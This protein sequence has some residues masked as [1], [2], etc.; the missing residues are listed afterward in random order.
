MM[1]GVLLLGNNFHFKAKEKPVLKPTIMLEHKTY[2]Y[3]LTLAGLSEA[4]KRRVFLSP[5]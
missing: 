1:M 4:S 2:C 3:V 5:V